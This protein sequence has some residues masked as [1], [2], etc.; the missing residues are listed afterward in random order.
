MFALHYPACALSFAAHSPPSPPRPLHPTCTQGNNPPDVDIWQGNA[1]GYS[2]LTMHRYNTGVYH[3]QRGA[4]YTGVPIP[5]SNASRPPA[6]CI[7]RVIYGAVQLASTWQTLIDA[8]HI[9]SRSSPDG[10]ISSMP[11]VP[12]MWHSPEKNNYPPPPPTPQMICHEKDSLDMA[13]R[14][15]K[16]MVTLLATPLML[17]PPK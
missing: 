11:A 3:L 10:F 14:E 13:L 9:T 5:C 7:N 4:S 12:T 8:L 2:S 1:M 15:A 16:I 17:D 6:S